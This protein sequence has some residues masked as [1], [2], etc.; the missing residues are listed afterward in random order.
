[1][2]S[3]LTSKT[4]RSRT[5]HCEDNASTRPSSLEQK[6][7]PTSLTRLEAKPSNES[8]RVSTPHRLCLSGLLQGGW[9]ESPTTAVRHG[10]MHVAWLSKC[11][12]THVEHTSSLL[13]LQQFEKTAFAKIMP[14]WTLEDLE[15][16]WPYAPVPVPSE[17]L[18]E[19]FMAWGGNVRYCLSPAAVLGRVRLAAAVQQLIVEGL[20]RV[21]DR[22]RHTKPP[23]ASA[24]SITGNEIGLEP[25][26]NAEAVWVPFAALV[27]E[28]Y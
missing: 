25:C 24:P 18:E 4:C 10:S 8:A 6:A 1:M 2:T 27:W 14:P 7:W 22:C 5:R 20:F 12:I 9:T 26:Q 28:L 21:L 15:M 23:E 16:A 13:P 17:T 11:T 19:G 3:M